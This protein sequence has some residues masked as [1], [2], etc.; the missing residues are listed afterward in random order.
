VLGRWGRALSVM[1]QS[2]LWFGTRDDAM[3]R[4][5]RFPI[6]LAEVPD[7]YFY[8]LPVIDDNGHKVARHYGAVEQSEPGQIARE[9]KAEDEMPV[10]AFL[11]QYLPDVTGP[12]RRMQICIYTLTPDRHFILDR[13]P[14]HP[15]VAIAAGFSGHGFK[16]APVVGEIMADLALNGA[17]KWPIEMFKITR[18]S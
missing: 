10:Q 15:N 13:H 5:D 12:R 1:R 11:N 2:M 4:R 16:F 7:G 14:D 17:T 8:G 6:Y 18:F 3:F 9:T